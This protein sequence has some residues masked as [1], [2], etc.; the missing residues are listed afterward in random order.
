MIAVIINPIAGGASARRGR[1]A[2]ADRGRVAVGERRG[3]SRSSSPSAAGTPRE[4]AAAARGARRSPRDRVGRRRDDERGG[5][6][7]RLRTAARSASC[8]PA[9]ATAWRARSAS[10]AVPRRRWRGRGCGR[11]AARVIDAGELGGRL[12]FN[13][14][15]IGFDA[16]VAACFDRD[17]SGRRGLVGY[18]RII[19]TGAAFAT[20]RRRIGF[21]P[22]A[23]TFAGAALLVTL[24][25]SPQFGNGA[26]IA[27]AARLDDGRLDLVVFEERSRVR[28]LLAAAAALHRRR[29]PACRA[30]RSSRSST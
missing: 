4:L 29:R 3:R 16:H 5:I 10:I 20:G 14:A 8:P 11:G 17:L 26:R 15:G 30:C 1:R 23:S 22:T 21:E 24:A 13:V 7:A 27:P 18:V 12:F 28:T 9:R 19:C 6:G 25:N 2:R